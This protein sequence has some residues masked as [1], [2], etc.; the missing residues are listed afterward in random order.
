MPL[1]TKNELLSFSLALLKT[2]NFDNLDEG[3]NEELLPVPPHVWEVL[4][5]GVKGF[6][7]VERVE[8]TLS[9]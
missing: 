5:H 7:D 2:A 8:D 6:E 3:N 4:E 1:R 9:S